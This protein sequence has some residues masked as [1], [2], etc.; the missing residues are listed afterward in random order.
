MEPEDQAILDALTQNSAEIDLRKSEKDDYELILLRTERD[1]LIRKMSE[2]DAQKIVDR[3]LQRIE[4][5]EMIQRHDDR[6]REYITRVDSLFDYGL[7]SYTDTVANA[8]RLEPEPEAKPEP[9]RYLHCTLYYAGLPFYTV[10]Q[11]LRK[12]KW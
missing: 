1:R 8:K 4:Q 2:E 12:I 9:R 7:R 10:Y 6:Q 3:E 5:R 11:V